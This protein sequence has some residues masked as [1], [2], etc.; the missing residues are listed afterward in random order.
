MMSW[1]IPEKKSIIE[2][3]WRGT[4]FNEEADRTGMTPPN[5]RF[6]GCFLALLD[7]FALLRVA[8]LLCGVRSYCCLVFLGGL[9]L[10]WKFFECSFSSGLVAVFWHF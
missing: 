4:R 1:K 2:G 7:D 9:L 8:V 5:Q 3:K 10:F 6:G